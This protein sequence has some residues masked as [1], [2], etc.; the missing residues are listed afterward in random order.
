VRCEV[1]AQHLVLLADLQSPD[2]PLGALAEVYSRGESEYQSAKSLAEERLRQ[3]LPAAEWSRR[4]SAADQIARSA[5]RR[6]DQTGIV[7][8]PAGEPVPVAGSTPQREVLTGEGWPEAIIVREIATKGP[9]DLRYSAAAIVAALLGGLW[10]LLRSAAVRDVFATHAPAI[11]AA[12]GLGWWLLAPWAWLGWV[13]IGLAIWLSV[14]S[15]WRKRPSNSFP[16]AA[17]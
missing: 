3:S 6:M 1:W 10:L 16:R 9:A 13:F 14:G 8:R 11:V 4:L 12:A 5:S 7:I 2:L 17:G 15:P